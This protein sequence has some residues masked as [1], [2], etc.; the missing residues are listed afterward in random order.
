MTRSD[1][2]LVGAGLQ[3][4][5]VA[6][7]LAEAVPQARV[8]LLDQSAEFGGGHTWCFHATDLREGQLNYVEPFVA[9]RWPAHE[10]RFP[11][12]SR[13]MD[14]AYA[15]VTG[16]SIRRGMRALLEQHPSF[17][18][19]L[20]TKVR[21]VS[22]SEVHLESGEVLTAESVIDARGPA[23]L[24]E[25]VAGYQKFLGLELEL[26]EP[27]ELD[28]PL[29]MD[30][31]VP[32]HD[33]F[34]F[35]YVL[36]FAPQRVLVEDTYFSDHAELDVARLRDEV[37]SYAQRSNLRVARVLREETGVLPLP[38]RVT[39]PRFEAPLRGGYAG[40]W[41][42]PTTGYSFP[43]AAR[44]AS[45]VAATAREPQHRPTSFETLSRRHA[46]QLRFGTL[47]NWLLFR[48]VEP[49][50][51]VSVFERFYRLPS[52]TIERFYALDTTPL[53]RARIVCGR[54]PAGM[55]LR[56]ALSLGDPA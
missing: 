17:E 52:S 37:L 20:N 13:R 5:L 39:A 51:R 15:S 25:A 16:E 47:L 21:S 40:G 44:F 56:R 3:N 41:L 12:L 33:G 32:Q 9:K 11:R 53:D 27:H 55:S 34:R 29:L 10:V 2:L 6:A 48:A 46:V 26:S 28:C 31:T 42:H 49:E 30:A 54:P 22:G 19:R 45:W 35:F 7:A 23:E 24:K 38:T 18:L 4:A 36:P 43:A 1:Y 8:T 50:Q 14:G